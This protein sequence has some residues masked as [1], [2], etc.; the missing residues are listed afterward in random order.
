MINRR[1]F[2]GGVSLAASVPLLGAAGCATSRA[3]LASASSSSGSANPGALPVRF[4]NETGRF[5]DDEILVYVVGTDLTTDQHCR[6]D[7]A[8]TP[9]PVS[10]GDNT[11]DGYTDYSI[12]LSELSGGLTL[13]Y[14]SGR[15]YLALG[16]KLGIRIVIDGN[17][18]PALQLPAGWVESDHGFDVLHDTVEFTHNEDGMFCNTSMVDQF[19]VPIGI[20]LTGSRDQTTGTFRPGGRRA[21]F[22]TL[23]AD[24][25]FSALVHED[26][27][28]IA[29]GHALDAGFFPADYFD[30]YVDRVWSHYAANDLRVTTNA[31]TFT[32]RVEGGQLVFDGGVSPIARPTT[33]DIL[34]CDGA[35]NAPNDGI[36]GPVA[37]IVG[38]AFNR[39]T[40]LSH[41]DQPSL[42]PAEFYA[43]DLSNR[44]AGVFHDHTVDGKAY[45]FAFDDVGDFASYV[46]DHDPSG[47]H[48][49]LTGF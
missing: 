17:G 29:P 20:R 27:R 49:T 34:F 15:I 23:A 28:V 36:T 5:S 41:A 8:G 35:L 26:L 2:L 45:G 24:P 42:D 33:R 18:R 46:Q 30:P 12:P 39:G 11:D 3:D 19:S 13:P 22:D 47:L 40:L 7:A 9:H 16:G 44:Y 37:A 10:E 6:V 48:V 31:G 32:G 1:L 38:A 4:T 25:G 43:S 21:V 14:M